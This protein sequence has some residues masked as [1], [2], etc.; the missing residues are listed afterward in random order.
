MK[1]CLEARNFPHLPSS[2]PSP[3][4]TPFPYFQQLLSI[5]LLVPSGC[6]EA[7]AAIYSWALGVY[8]SPSQEMMRPTT[9]PWARRGVLIYEPTE[10]LR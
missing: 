10:A 2:S 9:T 4:S 3:L 6:A 5:E 8:T 7:P 1:S